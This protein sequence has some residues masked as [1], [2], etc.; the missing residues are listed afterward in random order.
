MVT[1]RDIAKALNI[2]NATVSRAFNN[3]KITEATK[4]MILKAAAEMGYSE[5]SNAKFLALKKPA[6]LEVFIFDSLVEKYTKEVVNGFESFKKSTNNN[7]FK[8]NI[9]VIEAEFNLEKRVELQKYHILKALDSEFVKGVVF[10]NIH[11]ETTDEIIQAANSK[12]ILVGTFDMVEQNSEAL[13]HVAPDYNRLGRVA[14]ELL[15]KFIGKKGE[16]LIL[17]FNEGY[18]LGTTRLN[19]FLSCIEK[20]KDI[21]VLTPKKL[22]SLKEE[23]FFSFLDQYLNNDNIVGIYPIYRAEYVAK[24][25]LK[26][27]LESRDLKIISNDMNE[28]I[29]S[30]LKKDMI[31]GV[32]YQ[33][34]FNIGYKSCD[35]MYNA[36]FFNQKPSK[37]ITIK[38]SILIK[39]TL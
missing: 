32:I 3:G 21:T 5:D 30:F 22:D 7:K 31:D 28:S 9:N 19:G 2:S 17:D 4:E 26:N 11:N 10:S 15:A 8:V 24:Y 20:F 6:I 18:N 23:E 27:G 38:E 12:N 33:N 16:I 36:I 1:Q 14:G 29:E 37:T 25:I 35:L 13:F 34:P 39:E